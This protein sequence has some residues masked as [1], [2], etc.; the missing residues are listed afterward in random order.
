MNKQLIKDISQDLVDKFELDKKQA[1]N[2]VESMFH[3]L[4]EGLQNEKIVKIKGKKER[5][6][7]CNLVMVAG[8]RQKALNAFLQRKLT[9]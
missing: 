9:S 3:V 6:K 8:Y 4:Q 7:T 2:F 1:N 5:V